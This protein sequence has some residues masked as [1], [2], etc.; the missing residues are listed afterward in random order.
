MT[1]P[2]SRTVAPGETATFS[3]TATGDGPLSYQWERDG[4]AIS[5]ATTAS[6]TTSPAT[7]TDNGAKFR[8]VV[9]NSAGSATSNP[10]TCP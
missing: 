4:K 9:R 10:A 7:A 3:T 8:V 5:S 6:Y 2:S 1:H